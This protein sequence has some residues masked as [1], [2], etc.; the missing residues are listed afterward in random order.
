MKRLILFRHGKSD[1]DVSFAN[2]HGRPLAGRG[3]KAARQMGMLL[4]GAGQVPE[5]VVS[6]TAVRA[7]TTAELAISAGAW[8]SELQFTDV[9]YA[10]SPP[11]VL[12]FLQELPDSVE[13]VMLVGHEPTWSGLISA[14]TGAWAKMPTAAMAAIQ[15]P[16]TSRW[17]ELRFE[18]GQLIWLL[19]PKLFLNN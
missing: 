14:F 12:G 16:T 10:S 3:V 7:K 19:Q 18:S 6:S 13:D 17:R 15:F 4:S 11:R 2:D 9:L 1:W 8:D 5:L